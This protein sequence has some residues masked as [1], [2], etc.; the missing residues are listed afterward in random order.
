MYVIS[1]KKWDS[2]VY[3][4]DSFVGP[5][6]PIWGLT[7][8]NGVLNAGRE[9]NKPGVNGVTMLLLSKSKIC[10]VTK[11]RLST[12]TLN[13]VPHPLV[14]ARLTLSVYP[15]VHYT[16][17]NTT[18]GVSPPDTG[19]VAVCVTPRNAVPSVGWRTT[20]GSNILTPDRDLMS[21]NHTLVR[22]F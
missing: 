13:H 18:V 16:G 7:V 15:G 20:K 9:L 19:L 10:T 22:L 2:L 21:E 3:W 17:K 5:P 4:L 6:N 8:I 14:V 11:I 12:T 1:G